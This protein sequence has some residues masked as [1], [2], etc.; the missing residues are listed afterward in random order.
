MT[1]PREWTSL[2]DFQKNPYVKGRMD[3]FRWDEQTILK[4][5]EYNTRLKNEL[6]GT[7]GSKRQYVI[8]RCGA[9]LMDAVGG[10][11]SKEIRDYERSVTNPRID[12][13]SPERETALF[14]LAGIMDTLC[15]N[16]P[17][18]LND[19]EALINANAFT[20]HIDLVNG[21]DAMGLEPEQDYDK[22][23]T[24]W[25]FS[26]GSKIIMSGPIVTIAK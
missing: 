7:T 24:T 25:A 10:F 6:G 21:L 3:E 4:I 2:D 11:T 5:A 16:G 8:A 18:A 12:L 15:G 14:G 23:T 17:F 19:C 20:N 26:D 9:W 13:G 22:E 1:K